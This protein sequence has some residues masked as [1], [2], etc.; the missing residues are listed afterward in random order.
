MGDFNDVINGS[1]KLGGNLVS[2]CCT[3]AYRDCMNFCNMIDLGYSRAVFTWINRRDV[4]ALIQQRI[5]RCRENPSWNLA[6]PDAN[7]THLSQVSSDH[8]PLPLSLYEN[9]HSGL[10]RPFRFEKMWLN[11]LG[12]QQV[13]EN[14]WGL[15]LS[16]SLA[17][18]AFKSLATT[19]NKEIF[20]NIFVRKKKLLARMDGL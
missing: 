11:L 8:C 18:S 9:L 4:N 10:E 3:I 14:A 20:G 1:E 7:V 5:D 2:L 16:L 12:F 13:M 6:F 17:I 19:W 15:T